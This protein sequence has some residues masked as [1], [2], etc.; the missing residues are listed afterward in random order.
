M[1]WCIVSREFPPFAGGGIGTYANAMARAQARAALSP[2]VITVGPG[3]RTETTENGVT[4]VRLPLAQGDDWSAPHP[5]IRTPETRAAWN[6]LGPHSV[7]AMQVADEL[8]SLIPRNGIDLVEFADTG[9]AGWFALNRR[10]NLG[11]YGDVRMLTHIHS[12][13]AWIERTNRRCEPGRAMHE[14]QRMEREQALWSDAV[15]TPSHF[16]AG[17]AERHWGVR[18][19]VLRYPMPLRELARDFDDDHDDEREDGVLFVGRLEY[20]KGIDTLLSAWSRLKPDVRLHLVGLDTPDERTGVAI[21]ERLISQMP[22]EVAL[23]VVEHGPKSPSEVHA[24]QSEAGLVVVPSPEDNLPFTCI[25]A[26]AAAR[27]V[28]ASDI[29][30]ASELIEDGVSGLIFRSGSA[31]SLAEVLARALAMSASERRGMGQSA[32]ARVEELCGTD[33][34]LSARREHARQVEHWRDILGD[35]PCVMVNTPSM[36]SA[37]CESLCAALTS[38]GADVAIGWPKAGDRVVAH[39]TPSLEGLLAGPREVGHFVVRQSWL[40]RPEIGA[41]LAEYDPNQTLRVREAWKLV[42]LLLSM[43]ARGVAVPEALCEAAAPEGPVLEIDPRTLVRAALV[44]GEP[45]TP[46][47]RAI[48]LAHAFEGQT[49]TIKSRVM[50][51]ARRLLGG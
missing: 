45:G 25:E 35:P 30:G 20:R 1:S 24:L 41:L 29:G 26:M 6:A 32:R 27:V 51:T 18:A 33:S 48:R 16:M 8:L 7:F 12:P 23:T 11:S 5:A 49:D 42:A 43:G 21:G 28:I 39:A 31:A 50:G 34:A 10:R 47:G 38:S 37:S 44:T 9:A 36:I 19:T 14:L 4:V 17:W 3:E 22:R 13:S 2:V 40:D 46:V 15:I